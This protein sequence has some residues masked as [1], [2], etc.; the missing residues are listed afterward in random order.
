M[1]GD[2]SRANGRKGGRPKGIPAAKT[3]EK[4]EIR[5]QVREH[6]SRVLPALLESATAAALGVKYA[7]AR[8][9][10][11]GRFVPVTKELSE[12]ILT[13]KDAEHEMFEVWE[14]KPNIPAF[15]DLMNRAADK[16]TEAI[17]QH[18]TGAL[19]ITWKVE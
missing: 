19:E 14:E 1:P 13:G 11:S 8:H 6:V 9:R 12:A 10:A 5:R 18:H 15:T 16:P 17:E 3:L 4:E 2:I 7:V